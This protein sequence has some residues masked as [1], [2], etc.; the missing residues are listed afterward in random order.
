MLCRGDFAPSRGRELQPI[1]EPAQ[2]GSGWENL[3]PGRGELDGER[4]PVE[5]LADLG[6]DRLRLLVQLEVRAHGAGALDEEKHSLRAGERRHRILALGRDP[7]GPPAR[8][9]HLEPLARAE[10]DGEDLRGRA[11]VF[12][13]VEYDEHAPVAELG[14]ERLDE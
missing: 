14:F 1:L 4:Q 6:D 12:E 10:E 2:E 3:C 13:V 8:H 7:Q 11:D 5:A 9:Q